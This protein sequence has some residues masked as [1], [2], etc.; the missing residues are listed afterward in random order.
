MF[1]VLMS[2][3]TKSTRCER[4]RLSA[5]RPSSASATCTQPISLSRPRTMRRMVEK[6]STIRNLSSAGSLTALLLVRG[7]CRAFR[8]PRRAVEGAPR[9]TGRRTA[10]QPRLPVPDRGIAPP[11]PPDTRRHLRM[12]HPAG[13]ALAPFHAV[14]F[15]EAGENLERLEQ[16][17]LE[18]DPARVDDERLNAVFR[19]AH[20]VKGGAAT[21]GFAELAALTHRM[22]ALL[23]RMRRHELAP[24]AA[25]IDALLACG[26]AARSMLDHRRCA[27]GP[28]PD[29]Q[30]LIERLQALADAGA[31][32]PQAAGRRVELRL[33]VDDA[34]AID[35]VLELFGEIPNLG[36]IET[37]AGAADGEHRF[38]VHTDAS[39][40]ELLDLLAF[41]VDRDRVRLT[42]LAVPPASSPAPPAPPAAGAPAAGPSAADAGRVAGSVPMEAAT[43]RVGVDKV[44][45][46]LDEVGELLVAQSILAQA[47]AAL[48]PP[49]RGALAAALGELERHARALQDTVMS[50]RMVPMATVYA[51]FPRL[52]R[53]LAAQL[54]K[55]V[56]LVLQ[57]ES[58]ELDKGMVE[59]LV[60]PLTH[61]VRN[62]LDHGIETPAER[63]AGGK[64]AT[65][66]LTLSAS[67]QAGAVVVRSEE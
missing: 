17:L 29:A 47:C 58:T 30:P 20:S 41:H 62:A 51:R 35:G 40:A 44:E 34:G 26:D 4:S 52:V 6:S 66:T 55:Q 14:F 24:A 25:H 48:E 50:V 15:E 46:L 10:I 32:P 7:R 53:D 39:D 5:A 31:T 54:G 9:D 3:T 23:D 36:R 45:R 61:L 56:A 38:L 13:I 42:P 2:V 28:P 57:G 16:L 63:A 43:L 11:A 67:H 18:L 19:C 64:A 8:T 21:F 27:T 12:N 37:L 33:A 60:D 1:G 65:G 22:E 59:H 49:A